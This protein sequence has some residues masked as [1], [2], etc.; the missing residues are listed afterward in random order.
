M[1]I[2]RS[3]TCFLIMSTE[4]LLAAIRPPRTQHLHPRYGRPCL[5]PWHTLLDPYQARQCDRP[6]AQRLAAQRRTVEQL[7]SR[8]PEPLVRSNRQPDPSL[9][10]NQTVV[11]LIICLDWFCSLLLRVGY[12][13]DPA[14]YAPREDVHVARRKQPSLA[15]GSVRAR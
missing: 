10:T 14:W 9:V 7:K 11:K 1:H 3:L 8:K 5:Q 15:A 12:I 2:S 6:S 4:T 13:G